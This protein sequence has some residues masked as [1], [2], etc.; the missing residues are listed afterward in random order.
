[1]TKAKVSAKPKKASKARSTKLKAVKVEAVKELTPS[2]RLNQIGIEA[3][4]EWVA[5]GES[6]RSW[7]IQNKFNNKTVI[8]WIDA[9]EHRAKHYARARE[10]RADA[11]FEALDD[12]AEKAATSQSAV[13]VAGLRLKADT[14]KW[15]LAR[16]SPKKYGD[17]IQVGGADD[18]PP[19]RQD[20]NITPEEAYRRMLGGN[21]SN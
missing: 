16:M 18:L 8:D 1:M 5:N 14:I 10:D 4:C 11:V 15:K 19:I 17:K 20:V 13:E 12:L 7:C 3:I 6:L 2:E 9:D 21:G